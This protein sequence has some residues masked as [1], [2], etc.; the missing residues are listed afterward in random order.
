MRLVLTQIKGR[1]PPMGQ[2]SGLPTCG[3]HAKETIAD[4]R[5]HREARRRLHGYGDSAGATPEKRRE[6]RKSGIEH[7]FPVLALS[8]HRG[9][10]GPDFDPLVTGS[11]PVRPTN[12][13]KG[14]VRNRRALCLFGDWHRR[15]DSA[16]AVSGGD[17]TTRRASNPQI[18]KPNRAVI[19]SPRG[20]LKGVG[21]HRPMH[22]GQCGDG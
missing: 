19:A 22:V 12:L 15:A 13:D 5:R 17:L 4:Q 21:M 3:P 16:S 1:R 7:D 11:S 14:L 6:A 20:I 8:R 10:G 18:R 9:R 2:S